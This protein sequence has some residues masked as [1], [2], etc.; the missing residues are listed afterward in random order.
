MKLSILIPTLPEPESKAY[1]NSLLSVLS[2]QVDEFKSEVEIVIDDAG[3][4]MPTGAKRNEMVA[5]CTSDYFIFVDCDDHVPI[6]YVN[7]LL[8]AL[9]TGPDVVTFNGYMTTNGTSRVD[10]I[11]RLGEKYE[12]RGGK[13]YRFPN[14]ICAFKRDLVKKIKFPPIHHGEDYKWALEIHDKKLLKT[15]VHIDKEM[16]HYDFKTVPPIHKPIISE[17][18]RHRH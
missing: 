11:I 2:P 3:R 9:E 18:R 10:F 15:E 16:Y 8:T 12:E 5:N 7:E 4:H 6:Y 14:H 17:R 1:L 13:Y